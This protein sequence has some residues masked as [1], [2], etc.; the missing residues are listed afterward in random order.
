MD[1]DITELDRMQAAYKSSVDR[2]I[3]AIRAEAQ[4]ASVHHTVADVDA[5]ENAYF[6]A[7]TLRHASES[8]KKAYEAALRLKL[9]WDKVGPLLWRRSTSNLSGVPRHSLKRR[10]GGLYR[11]PADLSGLTGIPIS[12][13]D[14][15]VRASRVAWTYLISGSCSWTGSVSRARRESSSEASGDVSYTPFTP[16]QIPMA[17]KIL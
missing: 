2:W 10:D 13:W 4:L 15:S 11:G 8:A 7:E 16:F 3:A 17:A 12:S 9:F 1:A 6:L 14:R 5:W